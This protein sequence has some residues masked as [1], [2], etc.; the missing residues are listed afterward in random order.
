MEK[1]PTKN[2]VAVYV[3]V[4]ESPKGHFTKSARRIKSI[5][6]AQSDRDIDVLYL[7]NKEIFQMG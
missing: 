7:K 6:G 5:L 2:P 4:L 1:I 3:S